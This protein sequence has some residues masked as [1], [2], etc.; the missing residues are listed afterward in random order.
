MAGGEITQQM[1]IIEEV[2]NQLDIHL[3]DNK[4]FVFPREMKLD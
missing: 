2:V 1:R 4:P 3:T